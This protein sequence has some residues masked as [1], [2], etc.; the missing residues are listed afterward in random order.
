M[1][2]EGFFTRLSDC[3]V[4]GYE[5]G[6]AGC[7][8]RVTGRTAA[9]SALKSNWVWV[10]INHLLRHIRMCSVISI[11]LRLTFFFKKNPIRRLCFWTFVQAFLRKG[12]NPLYRNWIVEGWFRVLVG[13]WAFKVEHVTFF[14]D[15][16]RGKYCNHVY[17]FI[18]YVY[19]PISG[20]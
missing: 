13:S 14:C 9:G 2:G 19:C 4:A 11:F 7:G 10:H 12:F 17:S 1:N 15:T 8:L 3:G 6:S 16:L 20:T 18:D 5:V